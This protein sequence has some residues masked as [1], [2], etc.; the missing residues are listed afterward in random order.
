HRVPAALAHHLLPVHRQCE[1]RHVR[2]LR[3]RRRDHGGRAEP[4]HQHP[5]LQGLFGRVHRP[6]YRLLLGAVR[7]ADAVRHPPDLRAVPLCGTARAVLRQPMVENR[8][9]LN[10]LTHLVLVLGVVIVAFPVY[11]A[12]IAMTHTETVLNSG[13]PL[14]PGG[15]LFANL[16]KVW[17]FD[18]PGLPPFRVMV[19]NSTLMALIIMAGKIAISIVS[20]YAIVYFRFPFRVLAFW[21]IFITLMLPVEV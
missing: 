10:L 11:V 6:Q 1:L 15:E 4:G 20:A 18:P 14:L 8:P 5:G 17:N 16:E 7:G 3:H 19:W 12:V 2:H 9:F 13:A 21:I